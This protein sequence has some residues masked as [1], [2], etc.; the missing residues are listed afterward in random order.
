[1]TVLFQAVMP[2]EAAEEGCEATSTEWGPAAARNGRWG[3]QLQ[4]RQSCQSRHQWQRRRRRKRRRS[5]GAPL[6]MANEGGSDSTLKVQQDTTLL[7]LLCALE[8]RSSLTHHM[9]QFS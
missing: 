4:Q 5:Q 6:A 1:M 8:T 7:L 9:H 2:M 3:E